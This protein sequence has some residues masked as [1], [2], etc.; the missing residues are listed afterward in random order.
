MQSGKEPAEAVV[1][2][3]FPHAFRNQGD[4][5]AG[6]E[7]AVPISDAPTGF[8]PGYIRARALLAAAP[9]G[10][11]A[12]RIPPE[13]EKAHAGERQKRRFPR[14]LWG[15]CGGPGGSHFPSQQ[16]Q[17][18]TPLCLQTRPV[19][20]GAGKESQPRTEELQCYQMLT[21]IV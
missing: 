4:V 14:S 21:S 5:N 1:V 3:A 12:L 10:R 17:D 15:P 2:V 11:D 16:E 7:V 9:A 8:V 13:A 18:Q 19:L 20:P 6:Q